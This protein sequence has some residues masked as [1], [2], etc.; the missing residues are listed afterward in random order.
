MNKKKIL[1]ICDLNLVHGG[2]Q[3]ITIETLP[4]MSKF[5]DIILYMSNTPT[6]DVLT[7]L[8][9]LKIKI[10][11]DLAPTKDKLKVIVQRENINLLLIQ[12]EN[13]DWIL[14]GHEIKNQLG[15]NYTLFLYEVPLINTP[16]ITVFENWYIH[17]FFKLYFDLFKQFINASNKHLPN[18][19]KILINE[20]PTNMR[21]KKNNL[22]V[23]KK[24]H[25]L[26]KYFD[27][28]KN[29]KKG[30][31]GAIKL[32][33]MGE[34][35]KYYIDRY[36]GFKNLILVKHC[37]S[38]DIK[39]VEGMFNV[40]V[41]YDLCFMA[42]RLEPGKGIFD[43][44]DITYRVKKILNREIKIAI[45]GQFINPMIKEQFNKKLKRLQLV[46]NVILL[47]FVSESQKVE[48]LCSSKVFIYPSKKD[49]FSISLANALFCGLP[50]VVY[51]L[52]FVNQFKEIPIYKTKYRNIENMSKKTAELITMY[53]FEPSKFKELKERIKNTFNSKFNWDKTSEEQIEAIN[54]ILLEIG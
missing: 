38:S 4:R 47:G 5:F 1:Y 14:L 25:G 29:T 49:I 18:D 52:P 36:F 32:I 2:A 22:L 3:R 51:D 41:K 20:V 17:S 15:L 21:Y 33:A 28:I 43:I 37:A 19:N 11:I 6:Q 45:V 23:I 26:K 34:A 10:I 54:S 35:S 24:L 42:A 48:T 39:S 46:D 53:E 31:K 16:V 9:C 44:V 30:L 7:I 50:A 27:K 8:N 40:E 12:W 13:P